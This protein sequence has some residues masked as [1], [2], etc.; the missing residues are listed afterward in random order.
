MPAQEGCRTRSPQPL[1]SAQE[2]EVSLLPLEGQLRKAIRRE[3]RDSSR[4]QGLGRPQV[5]Q[6]LAMSESAEG[7]LP[8][9]AGGFDGENY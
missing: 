7:L 9:E 6:R 2:S 3:R 1:R 5:P 4:E 8:R